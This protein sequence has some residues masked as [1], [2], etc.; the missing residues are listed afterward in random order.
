MSNDAGA[1]REAWR[2]LFRVSLGVTRLFALRSGELGLSVPQARTLL[3]LQRTTPRSMGELAGMLPIDPS[4]MT[5]LVDRLEASGYVERVAVPLDR[6]VRGVILTERGARLRRRLI[7]AALRPPACFQEIGGDHHRA[8]TAA[9]EAM[10]EADVHGE[11][12]AGDP[13]RAGP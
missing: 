5:G 8:L 1:R 10:A 11:L 3:L 4:S 6:R 7:H 12:R 9:L 13:R 2:A